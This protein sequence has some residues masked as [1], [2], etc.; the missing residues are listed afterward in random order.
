MNYASKNSDFSLNTAAIMHTLNDFVGKYFVHMLKITN[1]P[2][3]NPSLRPAMP[4]FSPCSYSEGDPEGATICRFSQIGVPAAL[5]VPA[6]HAT[7]PR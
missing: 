4:A 7:L 1:S 5:R 6:W 3:L 2:S